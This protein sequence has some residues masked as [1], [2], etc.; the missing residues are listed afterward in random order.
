MDF[1]TLMPQTG[2]QYKEDGSVINSANSLLS[3]NST[4]TAR[5]CADLDEAAVLDG[6]VYTGAIPITALT[7]GQT[8]KAT[9]QTPAD[10]TMKFQPAII[11]ALTGDLAIVLYEGSTGLTGGT[12]Y[13]PSNRNRNS[14]N[15]SGSTIKVGATVTSNGTIIGLFS[16]MHA[17][18]GP[19]S[20]A[21]SEAPLILKSNTAYTLAITNSSASANAVSAE[22]SFIED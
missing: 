4:A 13:P 19:I 6:N 14:A 1:T 7:A 8:I 22:L 9:I 11:T 15:T 18:S 17:A 16:M 12:A 3:V 5:R 21:A 20:A 10:K 2:R